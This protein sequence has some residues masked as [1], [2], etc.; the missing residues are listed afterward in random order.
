MSRQPKRLID[1]HRRHDPPGCSNQSAMSNHRPSTMRAP[2]NA[3]QSPARQARC[4]SPIPAASVV[5]LLRRQPVTQQRFCQPT[6]S[7]LGFV[8]TRLVLD[9]PDEP[10]NPRAGRPRHRRH[11]QPGLRKGLGTGPVGLLVGVRQPDRADRWAGTGLTLTAANHVVRVDRGWNPAV[12]DQATDRAFRIGQRR[13]SR[14]EG[15]SAPE[16]SRR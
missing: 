16:R 9:L 3:A 7:P 12:E 15:A 10:L 4:C 6:C 5:S 8:D 14:C 11:T 13:A 2:V 1:P